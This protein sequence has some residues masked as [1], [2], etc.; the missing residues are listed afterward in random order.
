MY[1]VIRQ[2][3]G[4][5][6][7]ALRQIA[8]Q[9]SSELLRAIER[10]PGF[11]AHYTLLVEASTLLAFSLFADQAGAESSNELAMEWIQQHWSDVIPSM[12]KV[13]IGEVV[14]HRAASMR[15]P[16]G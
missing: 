2:Y 6:A 4:L 12:P 15:Q 7:R 1:A 3:D 10:A 9:S 16:V 11:V 5:D 14:A 13:T 8:G